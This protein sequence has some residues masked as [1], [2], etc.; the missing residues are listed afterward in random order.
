MSVLGQL[1]GANWGKGFL[2]CA[3]RFSFLL[4]ELEQHR[5]WEGVVSFFGIV[6]LGS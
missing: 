5:K 3:S 6:T 4:A 1:Q 2:V